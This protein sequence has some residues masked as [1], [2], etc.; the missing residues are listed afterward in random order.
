VGSAA[1]HDGQRTDSALRAWLFR[2]KPVDGGFL[3]LPNTSLILAVLASFWAFVLI[4]DCHFLLAGYNA[5]HS[6]VPVQGLQ[7]V[8]WLPMLFMGWSEAW[9]MAVSSYLSRHNRSRKQRSSTFNHLAHKVK[10]ASLPPTLINAFFLL[11]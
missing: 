1:L 7:G 11:G 9:G 5:H 4:I 6:I 3:I 8:T 10:P 2:R